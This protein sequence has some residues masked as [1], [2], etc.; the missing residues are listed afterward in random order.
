[1]LLRNSADNSS[2]VGDNGKEGGSSRKSQPLLNPA[3]H[4]SNV[5][6]SGKEGGTS[7]KVPILLILNL[8]FEIASAVLDQYSSVDK[9]EYALAAMLMAFLGLAISLLELHTKISKEKARWRWD[10]MVLL[11]HSFSLNLQAFRFNFWSILFAI[12]V[13][14]SHFVKDLR[15]EVS[16]LHQ[17]D[18]NV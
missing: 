17:T 9:P 15:P 16:V 6:D 8:A 2:N 13:L 10:T 18:K 14:C 3:D 12:C 5:G 1:M 11:S 4:S 7:R